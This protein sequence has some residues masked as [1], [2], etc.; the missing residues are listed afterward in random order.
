TMMI[1][2]NPQN[3]IGIV[4]SRATLQRL[5]EL[6]LKYHVLVVADEIHCDLTLNGHT[7]TP[8]S[9]LTAPVAH[10][11]ISCISPSKTFNVAALHAATL[12]IPDAHVRA[13][14]S[15][16]INNDELAEPNSFVIP[17]SIAAYTEGHDWVAALR[18]K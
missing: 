17:A 13:L 18:T 6:C 14:V 2:C 16:G 11:S 8:F 3:P 7:Y 4:W 10:N 9:S 1:L 5:G 12:I 15:R